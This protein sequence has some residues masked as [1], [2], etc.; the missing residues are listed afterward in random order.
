MY[1]SPN[2]KTS[3][4]TNTILI[5]DDNE[6]NCLLLKKLLEIHGFRIDVAYNGKTA[7]ELLSSQPYH[8]A[9]I[10]LNMPGMNGIEVVKALRCKKGPN[11]LLKMAAISAHA[12]RDKV[13]EALESGFDEYFI[14]PIDEI[15]LMEFLLAESSFPSV[16]QTSGFN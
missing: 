12:E 14:K 4:Q 6:I 13:A 3:R 5:A 16:Q 1:E 15:H 2:K 8:S 11:Q 7:L 10:D 9:F